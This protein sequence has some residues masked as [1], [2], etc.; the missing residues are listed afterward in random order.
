MRDE[1]FEHTADIP[2]SKCL[3]AEFWEEDLLR[4]KWGAGEG[5]GQED[6]GKLAEPGCR[7]RRGGDR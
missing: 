3:V 5:A 4:R 6:G 7:L 1:S 2:G